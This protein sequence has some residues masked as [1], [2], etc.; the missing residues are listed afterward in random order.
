MH[1]YDWDCP[2]LLLHFEFSDLWV[3]GILWWLWGFK[4]K[5]VWIRSKLKFLSTFL[6]A[7]CIQQSSELLETFRLVVVS[8]CLIHI[9]SQLRNLAF[10]SVWLLP[11]LLMSK[12]M[13]A[14]IIIDWQCVWDPVLTANV[15]CQRIICFLLQ[16]CWEYWLRQHLYPKITSLL[17]SSIVY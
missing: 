5:D 6:F 17:C 3:T 4:V 9:P 16:K 8:A 11:M 10:K 13:R 1:E 14:E 15:H 12:G 2:Q 7:T